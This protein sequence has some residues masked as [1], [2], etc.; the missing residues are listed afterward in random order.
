MGIHPIREEI[1]NRFP[2]MI[3][4]LRTDDTS[5]SFGSAEVNCPLAQPKISITFLTLG[6]YAWLGRYLITCTQNVP[7]D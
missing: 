4:G 7:C 3:L 2:F 6:L 1:E 5:Y